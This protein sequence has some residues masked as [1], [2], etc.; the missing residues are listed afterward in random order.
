MSLSESEIRW[1]LSDHGDNT[2]SLE[3]AADPCSDPV[4]AAHCHMS[5]HYV[6][7]PDPGDTGSVEISGQMEAAR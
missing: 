2:A 5:Q 4:T 6:W 7:S 1:E 3:H